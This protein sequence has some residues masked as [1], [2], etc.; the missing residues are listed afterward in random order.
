M[1]RENFGGFYEH[2]RTQ[3]LDN[4]VRK[5]KEFANTTKKLTTLKS[6][7]TFLIKCRPKG[8]IPKNIIN[9]TI[10]FEIIFENGHC[11]YD[12][13]VKAQNATRAKL[14][15]LEIKIC[16]TNIKQLTTKLNLLAGQINRIFSNLITKPFFEKQLQLKVE[17]KRKNDRRLINKF[18]DLQRQQSSISKNI[19]NEENKNFVNLSSKSIPNDIEVFLGLGPKHAV[20]Y[21]KTEIPLINIIAD[22]EPIIKNGTESEVCRNAMR[23]KVLNIITN[24]NQNRQSIHRKNY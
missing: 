9:G 24:F 15:N 10:I 2:L 7:Q 21:E 4:D 14:L 19:S 8:L 16:I 3:Y 17:M 23:S 11:L 20:P 6:Q 5:L 13:I 12:S 1:D 22:A 18:N